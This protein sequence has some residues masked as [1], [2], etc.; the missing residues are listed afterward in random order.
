MRSADRGTG[1]TG[2]P[3]QRPTP[4]FSLP[5]RLLSL[6]PSALA[7]SHA[8]EPLWLHLVKPYG[9]L[10][11]LPWER[12][13]TEATGHPVL[14]LPDFL[15]KPREDS[16]ALQVAIVCDLR[17]EDEAEAAAFQAVQA[18]WLGVADRAV[19]VHVFAS[20]HA[21][22]AAR[23]HIIDEQFHLH[24]PKDLPPNDDRLEHPWLHWLNH[25]VGGSALD[26]VHLLCR[27]DVAHGRSSIALS[28][29]Y[30]RERN[31]PVTYVSASDVSGA[32]LQAGRGAWSPPALRTDP[33]TRPCATSS[34]RWPSFV[35]D[36]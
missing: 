33:A 3:P 7:D 36:R 10:G 32:L 1:N 25:A 20:H 21:R 19:K 14:R 8:D 2:R 26:A 5:E 17:L 31:E 13:L 24:E 35:P 4:S 29:P 6:L 16:A 30:Q 11:T 15:E 12:L 27:A 9:H 34:T 18:A 28:R 23:R 22:G